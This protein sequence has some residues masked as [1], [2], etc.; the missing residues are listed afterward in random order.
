MASPIIGEKVR[1]G[2]DDTTGVDRLLSVF[3]FGEENYR[4]VNT[5]A[6]EAQRQLCFSINNKATRDVPKA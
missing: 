4:R 1:C 2:E 3:R 6:A 5:R